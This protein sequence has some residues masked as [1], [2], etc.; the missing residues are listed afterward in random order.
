[1]HTGGY[2][3]NSYIGAFISVAYIVIILLIA[4]RTEHLPHEFSRT[5]V[6]I[7]VT[8]W[9]LIAAFLIKDYWVA[10][11]IPVFFIFFNALNLKFNWISAINSKSRYGNYGTIYYAVSV[12]LLTIMTFQ[13]P[14]GQIV[15]GVGMLVMGYGDG[16]AALIG[17][18]YGKHVYHIFKGSKSL[19]GSASMLVVSLIVLAAYLGVMTGSVNLYHIGSIALVATL[20]E[21]ISP[22]GLDNIFVPILAS[23]LYFTFII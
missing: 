19:E 16:F 9:W 17:Q 15:G 1:M 20:V 11:S 6:H 12:T 4:I 3:L 2:N 21:A 8:N 14:Q 7:L 18:R 13:S 22:Y 5:M 10:V 23:L